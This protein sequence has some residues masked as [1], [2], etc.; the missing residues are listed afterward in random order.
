MTIGKK[1]K[2]IGKNAFKKCSK[3]KTVVIGKAV[4]TISAKAFASDNKIKTIT[5]KGKNLKKVKKNSFSK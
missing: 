4:K 3:L 5:F 2:S 1:V